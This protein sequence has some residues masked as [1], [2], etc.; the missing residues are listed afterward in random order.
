MRLT[1]NIITRDEALKI[2]P[3]FVAVSECRGDWF[4]VLC[5]SIIPVF[6]KL[7]KGQRCL[8]Y[9]HGQ[10]V[11]VKVSSLNHNDPRAEDGP[12]VRVG[13]GEMTW[14]VDGN[15]YAFPY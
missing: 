2:S 14:R 6:E 15:R 1:K 13:N 3:E 9:F 4:N 5:N 12:I 11:S 7:K 8:A 10:F